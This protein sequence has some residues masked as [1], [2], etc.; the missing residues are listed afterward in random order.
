MYRLGPDRTL[1]IA[2]RPW[3][4][5]FFTDLKTGRQ[6]ALFPLDHDTFFA[7]SAMYVPRPIEARITFRRGSDNAVQGV[8]WSPADRGETLHGER[9][10]FV[11]EEV[12]FGDSVAGTLLRPARGERLPAVV[13]LGG[14]DWTV[15]AGARRDAEI[16]ASFGLAALTFDR[17][18]SGGT[19][20]IPVHAFSVDADDALAAVRY[21]KSRPDIVSTAVGV[22]GRSQAGWVAPLATSK[23]REVDYMVIFVPP[24]VSPYEQEKYRRLNE[25]ADDGF[26]PAARN[27]ETAYLDLA[28]RYAE[29]REN[30]KEYRAALEAVKRKRFPDDVLEPEKPDDPAWDWGRENWRYNPVPA[31]ERVRVPVLAVFG[32]ADRNVDPSVNAPIMRAALAKAGNRDA[33]IL[34]VPGANHALNLFSKDLEQVPYHRQTG[35]GN[36]GW[37][38]VARWLRSRLPIPPLVGGA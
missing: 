22:T 12:K 28:V 6:G 38:D 27:E 17:R 2:V 8:D 37:P 11:E 35:F 32:G 3:G 9:C 23:G 18:G 13:V 16:F 33:T 19:P 24:A 21:L 1:A 14:S 26:D 5:L 20:G 29:T 7:G 25:L 10:R 31:L 15:R 34:V 30:W 4:E 36:Q